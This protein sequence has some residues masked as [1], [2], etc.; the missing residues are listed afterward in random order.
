MP[1][2]ASNCGTNI[3]E[4][5]NA[6]LMFWMQETKY[7]SEVKVANAQLCHIESGVATV[8]SVGPQGRGEHIGT[9]DGN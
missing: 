4:N 6:N 2:K 3:F 7:C 5:N 8:E 1:T 9:P